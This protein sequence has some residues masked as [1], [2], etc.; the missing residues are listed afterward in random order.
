MTTSK[1]TPP[2]IFSQWRTTNNSLSFQDCPAA[3]GEIPIEQH[4]GAFGVQRRFDIHTGIDVYCPNHSPVVAVETGTIVAIEQFTGARAGTP[5]WED[6]YCV[7]VEGNS[8]VVVY[9]EITPLSHLIFG[10]ILVQGDL[11]GHVTIVLKKDKGRP[12]SMLHL[13]LHAH[14]SRSCPLWVDEK[15]IYLQDPT[16]YCLPWAAK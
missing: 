4:V 2:L 15:P 14:G 6:T 12:R 13:E 1:W 16:P 8:G 9:G 11:I 10:N 5:W 7:M 3:V